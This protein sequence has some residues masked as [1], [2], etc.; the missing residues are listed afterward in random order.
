MSDL[1]AVMTADQLG[2]LL[3]ISSASLA[4]DRYLGK[5]VPFVKLG[6]RVRY[7]REDVLSYL[8]A[9]RSGGAA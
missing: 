1:P 3:G 2:Q 9:N 5:G 8:S 7:M 4:Q 6:K